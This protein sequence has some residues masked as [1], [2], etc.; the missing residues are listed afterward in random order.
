[1]DYLKAFEKAITYIESHL[2]ENITVED[3]AHAA[4]YSYY[5]FTRQFSAV[6]GESVG[7]YVKKRRLADGAQKLLYTNERIIDIAIEDGF[8]SGEA[9]CHA[10][11]AIYKVTPSIYRKRGLDLFIS[12][13]KELDTNLLHH[14]VKNITVHP[15]FIELPDI[16][17]IGLRG[18]T[19]LRNNV[20]PQ[21]W[22][23]FRV[24]AQTIPNRKANGRSFGIC[25]AC[26]EGRTL[27]DMNDDVLFSEVVAVEVEN[28]DSIPERLVPKT[29]KGGRYAVFTHKGSLACLKKTYDYI[30]GTWFLNTEE[31]LDDKE[32]FELYDERFLGYN[33][34]DS[35]I[36]LYVPIC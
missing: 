2:G 34:P 25:E 17:T 23:Q 1:M 16:K 28:Y 15:K 9:F 3:V 13:K 18:Q 36:D 30:W 7:S 14:L 19:N 33:H 35:K 10:F 29:L 5:H 20:L 27:Y 6:L 26:N 8:D 12:A 11:K 21:L 4:G 24:I 22:Q 31:T 32:D